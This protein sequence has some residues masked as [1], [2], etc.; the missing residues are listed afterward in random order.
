MYNELIYDNYFNKNDHIY[1]M[2]FL[3]K[4]YRNNIKILYQENYYN[5]KMTK[6]EILD[7]IKKNKLIDTSNMDDFYNQ[8]IDPYSYYLSNFIYIN[9]LK[10]YYNYKNIKS[11]KVNNFIQKTI[12]Y[13]YLPS[14]EIN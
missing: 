12:N 8:I 14:T 4:K 5:N 6:Q 7:D 3:L 2:L 13:L 10:K 1:K 11:S 9:E